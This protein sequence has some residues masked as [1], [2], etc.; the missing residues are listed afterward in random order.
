MEGS[1]P[2]KPSCSNTSDQKFTDNGTSKKGVNMAIS[3][4]YGKERNLGD[5]L[6]N[7]NNKSVF[8]NIEGGFFGRVTVTL[9][10]DG[11][12]GFDILKNY[13]TKDGQ[14]AS[15]VA[16]KTFPVKDKNDNVV[17]GLTSGLLGLIK[18]YDNVTGK[19]LVQ[20]NDALQI[21]THKLKETKALGESGLLKVGYITGVFAVEAR[22]AQ[23]SNTNQNLEVQDQGFEISDDE[24]PF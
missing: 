5:I 13:T 11:K 22:D 6:Y 12:G 16:G 18:R 24:I 4:I 23:D 1:Q 17:E 15:F 2:F 10:Q 21:T 9:R 20:N 7:P 14:P 19:E 8:A 3:R